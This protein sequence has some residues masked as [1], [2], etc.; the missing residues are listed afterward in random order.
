[1]GNETCARS[2]RQLIV[3]P[4]LQNSPAPNEVQQLA[5]AERSWSQGPKPALL[6]PSSHRFSLQ[7]TTQQKLRACDLSTG[8]HVSYFFYAS[9]GRIAI[10]CF[11]C[12]GIPIIFNQVR[13]FF[14]FPLG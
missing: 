1:M 7:D 13:G 8:N 4:K 2:Q 11:A 3:S 12:L 10:R 5:P 6:A 9:L 14:D